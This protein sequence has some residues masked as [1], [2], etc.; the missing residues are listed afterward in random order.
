[1]IMLIGIIYFLYLNND[2]LIVNG[3]FG[4][5]TS[6][7]CVWGGGYSSVLLDEKSGVYFECKKSVRQ[8]DPLS[9]YLFLIA[10]EGLHKILEK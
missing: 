6:C 2:D 10:V 1:M 7:V 5:N 4:W 8:G 9:P 3:L